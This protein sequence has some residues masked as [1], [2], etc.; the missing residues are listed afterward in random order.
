[1]PE[2]RYTGLDARTY[3][4]LGLTAVPAGADGGPTVAQFDERPAP[5]A[6]GTPPAP[7]PAGTRYAPT[8]GRWEPAT[9]PAAAK[10]T[11]APAAPTPPAPDEAAPADT[12]KEA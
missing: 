1:M 8:D 2:Y 3:P 7:V 5:P 12:P 11:A 6:D 4:T 10:K 9:P